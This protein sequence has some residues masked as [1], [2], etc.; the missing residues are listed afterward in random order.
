[1]GDFSALLAARAGHV[2][3]LEAAV[4]GAWRGAA[5]ARGARRAREAAAG[6]FY[7][8]MEGGAG[9]GGGEGQHQPLPLAPPGERDGAAASAAATRRGARIAPALSAA[10]EALL[11]PDAPPFSPSENPFAVA[12]A[13]DSDGEEGEALI[14]GELLCCAGREVWADARA[15]LRGVG[16]VLEA[17]GGWRAAPAPALAASYVT[18]FAALALP[19]LLTPHARVDA[20][21]AWWPLLR[22]PPAGAV[23]DPAALPWVAPAAAFSEGAAGARAAAAAAPAPPTPHLLAETTAAEEALVPLV[24]S[25]SAC[26]ALSRALRAGAMDALSPSSL[27]RGAAAARAVLLFEPPAAAAGELTAA[28]SVALAPPPAAQRD[29]A[30]PPLPPTAHLFHALLH[31]SCAEAVVGGWWALLGERAAGAAAG[32]HLAAAAPHCAA[33]RA[34]WGAPAA[35]KLLATGALALGGRRVTAPARWAREV[36]AALMEGG[37]CGGAWVALLEAS[38]R[39]AP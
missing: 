5:L 33:L 23:G 15:P 28:A 25:A 32:A 2:A 18:S 9:E 35:G 34:A 7:R 8:A 19:A 37:G 17:L 24:M 3:A 10:R 29:P 11:R 12:P 20:A 39:G 21:S 26:A 16:G 6:E 38:T 22:A 27:S 14:A 4:E 36:E 30:A 1:L 13:A 31:F